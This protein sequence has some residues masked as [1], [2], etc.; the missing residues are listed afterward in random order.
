MLELGSVSDIIWRLLPCQTT[1]D[2]SVLHIKPRNAKLSLVCLNVR[3]D[4]CALA[5][6]RGNIYMLRL[7]ANRWTMIHSTGCKVVALEMYDEKVD[8]SQSRAT[9]ALA[10]CDMS[11]RLVG[12][13]TGQ[14]MGMLRGVR[15]P[16][17]A[18]AIRTRP[19]HPSDTNPTLLVSLHAESAC[20][21]DTS[22]RR[23]SHTLNISVHA[24]SYKSVAHGTQA[25]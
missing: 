13:D 2:G 18:L 1:S 12:A 24:D 22:A 6:S 15:S 3:A 17:V 10:V 19:A 8:T 25:Q 4:R 23:L 20:I 11:I 9:L 16:A 21:W 5:D 14:V 7:T